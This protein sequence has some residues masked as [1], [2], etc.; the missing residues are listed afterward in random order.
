MIL[1]VRT[2]DNTTLLGIDTRLRL[3]RHCDEGKQDGDNGSCLA[4]DHR[5]SVL[6]HIYFDLFVVGEYRF[7]FRFQF[8][9]AVRHGK[10]GAVAVD[11][12]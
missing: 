10:D 8:V 12:E 2:K 1:A 6:V 5:S 9:N 4:S 11:E 3:P 7:E